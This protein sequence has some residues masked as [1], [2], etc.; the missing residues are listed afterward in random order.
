MSYCSICGE[1]VECTHPVDFVD[2]DDLP[3]E[4]EEYVGLGHYLDDTDATAAE[5]EFWENCAHLCHDCMK[6]YRPWI[7]WWG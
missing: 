7:V 2:A 3:K 6:K 5:E 4:L 1:Y